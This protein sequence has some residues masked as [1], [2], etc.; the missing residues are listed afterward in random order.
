MVNE[1]RSNGDI[2]T[3][4]RS[5][6]LFMDAIV[7]GLVEH[8]DATRHF[9]SLLG[10]GYHRATAVA[11]GLITVED[12]LCL[13]TDAGRAYYSKREL[14]TLPDGRATFWTIHDSFKG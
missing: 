9:G 5:T 11:M 14:N 13:L 6:R 4:S 7:K 3:E 2:S 8:Q 12:G 10:F 1:T